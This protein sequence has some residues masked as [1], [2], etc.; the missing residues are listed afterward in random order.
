MRYW[1]S[2]YQPSRLPLS[3]GCYTVVGYGLDFLDVCVVYTRFKVAI[4][5]RFFGLWCACVFVDWTEGLKSII[6]FLEK[7]YLG[8]LIFLKSHFF[9]IETQLIQSRKIKNIN[10]LFKHSIEALFEKIIEQNRR[11]VSLHFV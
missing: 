6:F 8:I 7:F 11:Y 1:V 5:G 3:V 4:G 10:K 9:L 2:G